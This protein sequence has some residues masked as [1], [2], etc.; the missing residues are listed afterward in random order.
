MKLLEASHG[1]TLSETEISPW[2]NLG[3]AT[4]NLLSSRDL[5]AEPV[6]RHRPE[7][8]PVSPNGLSVS[9]VLAAHGALRDNWDGEGAIAPG[10]TA[11]VVAHRFVAE[12]PAEASPTISASVTGGVLLEWNSEAVDL[13]LEIANGGTV[14]A[15]VSWSSGP[16]VEG[17]LATV[18]QHVLD[19]L[20]VLFD[21]V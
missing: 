11:I 10:V 8:R 7:G 17:P 1:S 12:L 9:Q 6:P 16:E 2:P 21:N 18:K 13:M 3:M 14:E 4:T 15:L 5:V 20:A 19:A